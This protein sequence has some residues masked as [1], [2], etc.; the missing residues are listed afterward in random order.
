MLVMVELAGLEGSL[1]LD[2]QMAE[3]PMAAMAATRTVDM[4]NVKLAVPTIMSPKANE[5]I[6]FIFWRKI[7]CASFLFLYAVES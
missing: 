1:Y 3:M 5:C 7:N 4:R 6:L 2:L